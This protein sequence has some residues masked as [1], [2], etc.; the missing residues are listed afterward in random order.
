MHPKVQKL[1]EQV[2]RRVPDLTDEEWAAEHDRRLTEESEQSAA[3]WEN[4]A[5]LAELIRH[6]R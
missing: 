3:V 6:Q 1:V 5:V 4:V 2:R